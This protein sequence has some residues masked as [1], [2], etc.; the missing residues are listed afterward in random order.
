V[1]R[2]PGGL[3][4]LATPLDG[5]A[6]RSARAKSDGGAHRIASRL[7][8]VLPGA[9]TGTR[10]LPPEVLWTAAQGHVED[11]VVDAWLAGSPV[12]VPIPPR[13]W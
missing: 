6:A 4:A 1:A 7:A 9:S 12:E 10:V 11:V 5:A 2:A 8:A 3:A 13:R